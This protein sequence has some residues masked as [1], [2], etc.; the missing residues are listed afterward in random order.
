MVSFKHITDGSTTV[1]NFVREARGRRRAIIV[2]S[3]VIVVVL[4]VG[5]VMLSRQ[6]GEAAAARVADGWAGL[7]RCL[8]GAPVGEGERASARLRIV[9]LG[10]LA[11]YDVERAA[12]KAEAW[13]DR[14]ARHAYALKEALEGS[15]ADGSRKELAQWA[16]KL[17][18]LLE[19]KTPAWRELFD[20]VDPTWEHA[21][22]SALPAGNAASVPEPPPAAAAATV[23][24][25][26]KSSLVVDKTVDLKAARGELHTGAAAL[27]VVDDASA[28]RTPFLCRFTAQEA[29]CN[30]LSKDRASG[31]RGGLHLLGTADEGA[32]PLVFAGADGSGGVFQ[33]DGSLTLEGTSSRG[34]YVSGDGFAAVLEWDA[35]SRA[36]KL[37]RKSGDA[38]A[39]APLSTGP[40]KVE[41]PTEDVRV[42]WNQLV[43]RGQA[44]DGFVLAAAEVRPKGGTTAPTSLGV[45]EEAQGGLRRGG[46]SGIPT[47]IGCRAG[48]LLVVRAH[49]GGADWLSFL[50]AGRWSKPVK[51]TAAG[52]TLGC[53]AKEAS[54]IRLDPGPAGGTLETAITYQ[55]CAPGGCRAS[56]FTLAEALKTSAALAPSGLAMLQVAALGDKLLVVWRAGEHG[57]VR[58]RLAAAA[59]LA[60]ASDTIVLDDLLRDGAVQKTSTLVDFRVLS[61]E[62]FAV[63]L[64][65]TTR[66]LHALRIAGDGK[67]APVQVTWQQ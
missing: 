38:I 34:G 18:G 43:V 19:Q 11:T 39:S 20:A 26:A 62:T 66:G 1:L 29:T 53:T 65:S 17:G 5:G 30:E 16:E 4:A 21:G 14:C 67:V 23:D 59:E 56:R 55:R 24:D 27:V 64:L 31:A 47:L 28:P 37:L 52:G 12:K 33:A 10:A 54:L 41:V 7:S 13:P 63:V 2:A 46:P 8:L 45:L 40:L 57:G 32:A 25:L 3:I 61:R 9:Q 22:K 58:M 35:Q 42:L 50:E 48:N 6:L 51:A 15:S 60:N 44:T 49:H 36:Y